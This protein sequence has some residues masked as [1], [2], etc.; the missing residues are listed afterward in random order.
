MNNDYTKNSNW[1]FLIVIG[2]SL[3]MLPLVA[4]TSGVFR[5]ILGVVYLMVIPGY[6][7]ISALFPAWISLTIIERLV[8]SIG[9]SVALVA[10]IG[11]ILNFTPFGIRLWPVVISLLAF[12]LVMSLITWMRRRRLAGKA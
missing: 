8:L 10:I 2:L 5:A 12:I 9:S 6:V 11:L 3:L 4:L 1:D 7:F